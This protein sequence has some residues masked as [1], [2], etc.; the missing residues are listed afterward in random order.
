M[1]APKMTSAQLSALSNYYCRQNR[2][3]KYF[4]YTL[5]LLKTPLGASVARFCVTGNFYIMS[6]DDSKAP[7]SRK[8][9]LIS[10]HI[11]KRLAEWIPEI[12]LDPFRTN[13]RK[14]MAME[15]RVQRRF[16]NE[17][18]TQVGSLE[19][20]LRDRG[21]VV[22]RAIIDAFEGQHT[23]EVSYQEAADQSTTTN[24]A[25][26]KQKN[27]QEMMQTLDPIIAPVLDPFVE[28]LKSPI[29]DKIGAAEIEVKRLLVGTAA[30]SFIT[31]FVIGRISKG[32]GGGGSK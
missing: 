29:N 14:L 13:Q 26:I 27:M 4:Y 28:G 30:I 20:I 18:R 3:S 17:Y 31:G 22:G 19:P 1:S 32:G 21:R 5:D 16:L 24:A 23:T 25:F 2:L 11:T 6:T 7:Q 8:L 10:E 9:P 12:F 15:R